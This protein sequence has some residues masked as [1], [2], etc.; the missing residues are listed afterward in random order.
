M[1]NI[2]LILALLLLLPAAVVAQTPADKLAAAKSEIKDGHCYSA[3]KSLQE[4]VDSVDAS[5]AQVE[6]ALYLQCM[7]Y[8]GDVFGAA[9][10][11]APLAAASSEG[12][13]LKGQV[14]KQMLLARRAFTAAANSYLNSTLSGGEL[15]KL[16]VALPPFNEMDMDQ[17]DATIKN[18]AA[19]K[20]MMEEYDKDPAAGNGCLAKASQFGFYLGISSAVPKTPGRKVGDVRKQLAA[21]VTFD[22]LGFLDW[23]ATV[24]RDMHSLVNEPNGPDLPGLSRRAD[25]RIL[26][27]AGNDTSNQYVKNAHKRA[28]K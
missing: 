18:Q 5:P 11:M 3:D 19:L 6:E 14:S 10:M 1:R 28:G 7:I 9:L 16:T 12:S 13:G 22:Q 2:T 15:K 26:K 27:L 24:A 17:L 21:G 25:E 8:Y 20:Q 23:L 4:I